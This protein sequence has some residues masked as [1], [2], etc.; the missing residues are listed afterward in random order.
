MHKRTGC[1]KETSSYCK[2]VNQK[3]KSFFQELNPIL[4]L[5]V[6]GGGGFRP[7]LTKTL[8]AQGSWV[9]RTS[10]LFDNS[11]I[12]ISFVV[13]QV[14]EPPG[15]SFRL[16]GPLFS[17]ESSSRY[18]NVCQSVSQSVNKSV[19]LIFLSNLQVYFIIANRTEVKLKQFPSIIKIIK[20][21]QSLK[22]SQPQVLQYLF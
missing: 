12:P 2:K 15:A 22:L 10:K 1:P 8:I 20:A 3:V 4:T 6:L 5:I 9:M 11:S 16:R 19:T 17:C 14:L 21:F 7:P 13:V 18:A